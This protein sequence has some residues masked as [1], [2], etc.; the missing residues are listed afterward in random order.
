MTTTFVIPDIH[1]CY[2]LMQAA[3]AAIEQRENKGK[4][5]F[6]GDYIDRGPD[7][8]AVISHLM[9]GAPEGWEW[10]CL[11][12]NHE[13]MMV[14]ALGGPDEGWWL[15]NGGIQTMASYAG[16]PYQEHLDW[17]AALPMMH[18]DKHRAYVHAGVIEDVPL[19]EEAQGEGILLWHRIP[20]GRDVSF[21]LHI[22][23]GHTP[24]RNGPERLNGRTNLDTGAVFT[25][26]L[27]VG[28]F[29]DEAPGGP[30]EV[31]EVTRA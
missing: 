16:R 25:G 7:S 18:K 31:I 12:G 24:M 3:L 29:D 28:V 4:V 11:K 21:D 23:H 1:G 13:D 10:V 14:G 8:A 17:C 6:L 30:V 15:G 22:V 9:R 27:V 26:R 2:D 19:T 20:E 5:V